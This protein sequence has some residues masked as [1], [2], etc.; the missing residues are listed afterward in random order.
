MP[1]ASVKY[2]LGSEQLGQRDH[3]RDSLSSWW[4]WLDLDETVC[5]ACQITSMVASREWGHSWKLHHYLHRHGNKKQEMHSFS[6]FNCRKTL[7]LA[8]L[9]QFT[10]KMNNICRPG[11]FNK[12]YFPLY[13]ASREFNHLALTGRDEFK[14]V[15]QGP[16]GLLGSGV[17]LF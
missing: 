13:A 4:W 6:L 1:T 11:F 3:F 7:V 17:E 15:T 12:F 10:R 16:Q 2:D 5:R 14:M 8:H 9:T